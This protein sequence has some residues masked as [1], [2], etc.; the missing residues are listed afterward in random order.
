MAKTGLKLSS[1]L[2]AILYNMTV[3]KIKEQFYAKRPFFSK[4]TYTDRLYIGSPTRSMMTL[5]S[6][7]N[8]CVGQNIV[9]SHYYDNPAIHT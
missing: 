9:K 5:S 7:I 3:T 1:P 4:P 6:L 2:S 8:M